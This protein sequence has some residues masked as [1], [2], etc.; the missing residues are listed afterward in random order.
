[1][2]DWYVRLMLILYLEFVQKIFLLWL[3]QQCGHAE[4]RLAH[5]YAILEQIRIY[6]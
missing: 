1:M 6:L 2:L 5:V 4:H 3:E